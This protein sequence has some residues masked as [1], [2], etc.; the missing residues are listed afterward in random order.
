MSRTLSSLLQITNYKV[1]STVLLQSHYLVGGVMS[2]VV[3][4]IAIF[5]HFIGF[6]ATDST[7]E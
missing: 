3:S 5:V 2:I 1:R 4:D 7:S 6:S